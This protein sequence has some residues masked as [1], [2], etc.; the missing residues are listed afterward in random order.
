[1]LRESQMGLGDANNTGSAGLP[2]PASVLARRR[3]ARW[4][5]REWRSLGGASDFSDSTSEAELP[6]DS[7][8]RSFRRFSK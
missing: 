6:S 3:P 5:H 8:D 4:A 2:Q 7:R 1:M